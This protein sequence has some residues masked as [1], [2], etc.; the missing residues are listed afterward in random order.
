[1]KPRAIYFEK[2]CKNVQVLASFENSDFS[3]I[4]V[5]S[6]SQTEKEAYVAA[7][8][9]AMKYLQMRFPCP[10]RSPDKRQFVK[11]TNSLDPVA[12]ARIFATAYSA[13]HLR[14]LNDVYVFPE[15]F[16]KHSTVKQYLMSSFRGEVTRLCVE[17]SRMKHELQSVSQ[18]ESSD[19]DHGE[20][21]QKRGITLDTIFQYIDHSDYP[22]LWKCVLEVRCII[23]A[24]V[25]WEQTFLV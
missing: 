13:C 10:S 6:L 1:M 20:N 3:L 7:I 25:S 14:T 9:V 18:T 12:E 15:E 16:L 19:A 24:T 22:L 17:M 4:G 11:T 21:L 2:V 5:V 23:P 8:K